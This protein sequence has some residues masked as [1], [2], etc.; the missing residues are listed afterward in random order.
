MLTSDTSLYKHGHCTAV[1]ELSI[2]TL[3]LQLSVLKSPMCK[4]AGIRVKIDQMGLIPAATE[5]GK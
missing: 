1:K 4:L 3:S 5:H 2:Y